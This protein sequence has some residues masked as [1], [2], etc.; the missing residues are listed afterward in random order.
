MILTT[1]VALAV[2]P[3]TGV[4]AAPVTVN[5]YRVRVTSAEPS[6][7]PEVEIRT[8]AGVEDFRARSSIDG[9]TF[10]GLA[11][12]EY[13]SRG[14][15]QDGS[16]L[17]NLFAT[18]PD[19]APAP[20]DRYNALVAYV[21]AQ[22]RGGQ[23]TLTAT[24]L[25]GRAAWRAEVEFP[26]NECAGLSP[27]RVRIWLARRTHL[28][29]RVVERTQAD[30]RIRLVTTYAYS[31]LNHRPP[32]ATFRPPPLGPTPFRANRG[33]IRAAP[34]NA[35][36]P[37]PYIPR[38]PEVLPTGFDLAIS[39]WA[40]RSSVTGAEGSIAPHPWLFAATF[41]RGQERI[42]VTQRVS[43]Q[44][45]PDDPFGGE[46]A[47][48]KT[49]PVTINGITATYGVGQNTVA[50]LYWRD[51]SLLYTVSGPYPRDDLVTIAASLRKL[52]S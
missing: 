4:P 8:V 28:P 11:G 37:L 21:L 12:T 32:A 50:H 10:V 31:R 24:T 40:R 35:S 48:L 26:A 16:V 42:E 44:D 43:R 47:P 34:A 27:R 2:A 1:A 41:T 52:G 15:G 30:G 3:F 39:G 19:A 6:A 29:L 36:G 18:R 49:E 33:F 38:L 7:R 25:A 46:C 14:P 9:I 22:S 17:R 5:A 23:L 45:W 51:G 20:F 13:A